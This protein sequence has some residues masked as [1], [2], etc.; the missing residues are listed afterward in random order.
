MKNNK[1]AN[2]A[3]NKPVNNNKPATV[4]EKKIVVMGKAASAVDVEALMARLEAAEAALKQSEAD[5]AALSAK[6]KTSARREVK[7]PDSYNVLQP[8]FVAVRG[9][10]GEKIVADGVLVDIFNK[11]A[12]MLSIIVD[13]RLSEKLFERTVLHN[14]CSNAAKARDAASLAGRDNAFDAM[15]EQAKVILPLIKSAKWQEYRDTY[16]TASNKALAALK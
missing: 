15:L 16:H 4:A 1:P 9:Y 13:E 11:S 10:I 14:S 3:S 8:L 5:K 12:D 2:K 7:A 6:V